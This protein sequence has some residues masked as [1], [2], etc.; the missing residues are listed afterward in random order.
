MSVA[1]RRHTPYWLGLSAARRANPIRRPHIYE[2]RGLHRPSLGYSSGSHS[3]E[4]NPD[5]QY[6]YR[7]RDHPVWRWLDSAEAA[8][9]TLVGV[10]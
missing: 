4:R 2:P 8:Q 1:V 6:L 3:A 7:C 5:S 9:K 10:V